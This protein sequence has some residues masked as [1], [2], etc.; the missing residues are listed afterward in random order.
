MEFHVARPAR[1]RYDF[2]EGLFSLNG[3]VVFPNFAASRRFAQK[4]NEQR[5]AEIAVDPARS[6]RPGD[7]NAMGLIDEVLHR[8]IE[9]YRQQRNPQLLA[10]TLDGL[11]AELGPAAVD[12]TLEAFAERF[13]T[14]AAYRGEMSAADYLAGATDG[15]SNREIAL[16]ELLLNWLANENPAYER[17]DELFDDAPIAQRTAYRQLIDGLR[18]RLAGE[19][20]FGPDNDDLVSLLRKPA[21]EAPESLAQQIQ[22]LRQR[23]GFA[24]GN[25]G[26]RLAI[27]LDVIHE[28]D[29]AEWLRFNPPG[30]D[31][32]HPI[33][34][35]ALH[36]FDDLGPEEER[37]SSDLDWMPRLVLLAKSTYVWLD[38]LARQYGREVS[39]LDQIPD[40]ELDRIASRG[41]SGLWLIGLWERSRAS[42]RIK[43]L[44]GQADAVAS[45]Y[46]LYDYQIAWDLGGE[47]G[48]AN[49]RER[50]W[51]RG[52]RLAS[53]MVP[54]HM[55]IDSRW[56]VEHPDW[57]ISRPDAPYPVYSFNGPDLSGDERVGIFLEDHYYDNSD[58]AVV[59]KR[60]DRWTGDE[61]YVYHGNDGTSF[62]WNDTAQLDFLS[63]EVREAVIQTILAVAHRFPVIRFDAAMV[64]AKRHIER[65]WYPEPG[66]GGAIPS[67]A[68]YAMSKADF[69]SRMPE[70]FWREVVDRVAAEAPDTLLLAEAFWLMEGYFVRT[71]GMHRVYN[72]A[73]MNMMRDEQ[74]AEYRLVIK[75][76]LEFDPQILKRYVNFMNNPDEKTAVEQFGVDNKYFGVATVMATMPGLP[77]FGHGQ[78]EGF[79]EKYGMEYRR[80]KYDEFINDG[81]VRRH[82]EQIFPLLHRRQLFAEVDGFALYDFEQDGG[83]VNEDVFAYSNRGPRGERTLVVYHNKYGSTAGWIR[84]AAVTGRSL[85]EGLGVGD[86]ESRFVV[87]RDW[88]GGLEYLRSASS[89]AREGLY[90]QLD[91]YRT[92]VFAEIKD[93]VDHT[94]GRW[95]RLADWLDGRGVPS[96]E[97]AMREMELAPFHEA[98][99]GGDAAAAVREAAALL[100]VPGPKAAPKLTAVEAV[101]RFLAGVR[102]RL[103]G[104][105]WI[106]EWLADRAL[107]NADLDAVRLRMAAARDGLS[108]DILRDEHFRRLIGANTH[109][110][111]EYFNKEGF[112]DT[113][114]ALE[115][116]T[117]RRR[118]LAA[119]AENSGY[120]LDRLGAQLKPPAPTAAKSKA[121]TAPKPKA[122]AKTTA[123][124]AARKTPR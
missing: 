83:G 122:K 63:A 64:L 20:G 69:N 104:G 81:L 65:L 28:D 101:D 38:Q 117:A 114:K 87:L 66:E 80:A 90:L 29:R 98:L 120:R 43:Q 62:P 119:V 94:D 33:D 3:N 11:A 22:W 110:G 88:R 49:L 102:P 61:R 18:Q 6:A 8:V 93:L 30:P 31:D 25:L 78:V 21:L 79:T 48:Y 26:D 51:Q 41:F 73:F 115:V 121:P 112:N 111:V 45:A 106:D 13:P 85:G 95:R 53:D 116:P 12:S 10:A 34:A 109:E 46:S 108:P 74:N 15:R 76:T 118:E 42:Q 124:P 57:F 107:P 105:K 17:Y 7:L 50:A 52:I 56:V 72:S 37:F 5:A 9:L 58:A 44:R 27:G 59:F 14:V 54:N 89:V 68:E 16:E 103:A 82:D 113:L 36:A 96:L 35:A 99:R 100:G 77:M 75:N 40:E 71:L 32:V 23:W 55:G 91:A 70:E 86:D 84:R 24:L 1:Q 97:V 60:V 19:P 4:M 92:L 39:R 2:D 47:D 123:K 67:R